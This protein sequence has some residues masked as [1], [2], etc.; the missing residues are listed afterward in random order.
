MT[1][2]FLISNGVKILLLLP[3]LLGAPQT[4]KAICAAGLVLSLL[5]DLMLYRR[6]KAE[7][8]EDDGNRVEPVP[9]PP[10]R[11]RRDDR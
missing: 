10:S 6:D 11:P 7:R 9:M 1:A 2:R 3:F 8:G 4:V 5:V